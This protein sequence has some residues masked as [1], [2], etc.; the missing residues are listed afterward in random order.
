MR[1]VGALLG[2]VLVGLAS[3]DLPAQNPPPAGQGRGA[4]PP[5]GQRG[6]GG[7]GAVQVMT[8][9]TPA[10]KDGGPIPI[11]HTQAG[12]EISPALSWTNVPETTASFV[13]IVHDIDAMTGG[14][15]SDLLHWLVWNIPGTARQLPEGVPQGAQLP[16]G[17]RQISGTGPYYRGPGAPASGPPHHYLFELF[18]LDATIDVA[19]TGASPAE[20][21]TAVFAA[22]AGRIR[23]KGTMVGTYKRP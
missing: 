7:R 15:Q 16:D 9:M 3:I 2:V 23:G 21:R 11:R 1:G 12:E 13:L 5:A 17:T 10:W 14:G 22:M 18:A 4:P 19:P 20:T 6:G 8:L